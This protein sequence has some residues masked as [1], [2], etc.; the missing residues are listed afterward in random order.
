MVSSFNHS[1]ARRDSQNAAT[2]T[3]N[4]DTGNV[5][6][7]NPWYCSGCGVVTMASFN[8]PT[9]V[10]GK[11]L[12]SLQFDKIFESEVAGNVLETQ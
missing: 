9:A 7:R 10:H 3:P 12:S 1:I 5:S 8:L 4:C 6:W 11:I 2:S